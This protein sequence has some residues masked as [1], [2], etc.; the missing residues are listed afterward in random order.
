MSDEL[1]TPQEHAVDYLPHDL[2]RM[3]AR[4][5]NE[6]CEVVDLTNEW[7]HGDK[8]TIKLE[9]EVE[10]AHRARPGE[11]EH[12]T[13]Q[14][15]AGD[16]VGMEPEAITTWLARYLEEALD[17]RVSTLDVEV[18]NPTSDGVTVV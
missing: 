1:T 10:E 18:I 12:F 2:R 6:P 11:A 14:I 9:V 15:W 8:E 4:L 16:A 13:P 5:E 3:A 17:V 7:I